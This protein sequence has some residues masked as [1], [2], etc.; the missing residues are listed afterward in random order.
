MAHRLD[1]YVIQGELSNLCR[2]SITGRLE[3]LRTDH[4]RS[5]SDSTRAVAAVS[6]RKSVSRPQRSAIPIF[7]AATARRSRKTAAGFLPL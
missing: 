2:N 3:V 7:P 5:Y 1:T 6:H 4:Q